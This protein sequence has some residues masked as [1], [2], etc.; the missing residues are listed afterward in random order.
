MTELAVL[1]D[2]PTY[3]PQ[4]D[5]IIWKNAG[6]KSVRWIAEKTGLSPDEVLRRKN[7][8]FDEVDELTIDQARQRLVIDIQTMMQDARKA[9]ENSPNEFKA[10]LYNTAMAGAKTLL[11]QLDRLEKNSGSAKVQLNE[12][13]VRELV[14]LMRETIEV[15]VPQIA[16][17]YGLEAKDL[18]EVFNDN[19]VLAAQK[20]DLA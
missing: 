10:G 2:E 4:I 6:I 13:R 1:V 5:K 19:L 16:E 20:R 11:T 14:S 3:S 8:L 7:Q 18:F 17:A 12:M 15:S 9:A